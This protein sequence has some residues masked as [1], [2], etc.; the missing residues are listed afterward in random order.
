MDAN[1][2]QSRSQKRAQ[3]KKRGKYENEIQSN[4]L[5]RCWVSTVI[6]NRRGNRK[7]G[8][9]NDSKSK[10]NFEADLQRIYNDFESILEPKMDPKS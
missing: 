5:D 2:F 7:K 8:V 3:R 10:G 4:C 6:E 9:E 1:I